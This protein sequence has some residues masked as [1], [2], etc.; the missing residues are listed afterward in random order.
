MVLQQGYEDKMD[1]SWGHSVNDPWAG[2]NLRGS[3][4]T[5]RTYAPSHSVRPV[6][7]LLSAGL[8]HEAV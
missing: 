2:V 4:S 6:S 5:H 8:L 3:M 7:T 1:E